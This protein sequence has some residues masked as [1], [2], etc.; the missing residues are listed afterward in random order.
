MNTI[1]RSL[2]IYFC[3]L[4]PIPEL[5]LCWGEDGHFAIESTYVSV[6]CCDTTDS[7]HK[8]DHNQHTILNN[9]DS[10]HADC[11]HCFDITFSFESS[12]DITLLSS[13]SF[14]SC[15]PSIEPQ[16]HIPFHLNRLASHSSNLNPSFVPPV[17]LSIQS[18]RLLI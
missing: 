8:Y 9:D 14:D 12:I 16:N 2:I 13:S 6:V 5:D 18:T 15:S 4:N 17:L 10:E 11:I 1:I 3:L 7:E